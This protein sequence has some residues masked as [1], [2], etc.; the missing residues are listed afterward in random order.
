M[1]EQTI[2]VIVSQNAL[3]ASVPATTGTAAGNHFRGGV[4]PKVSISG[5]TGDSSPV[6]I[7]SAGCAGPGGTAARP[8]GQH[9]DASPQAQ[10]VSVT[11]AGLR[12]NALAKTWHG[13]RSGLAHVQPDQN[14]DDR[15]GTRKLA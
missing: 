13:H 12:S 7:G 2:A 10:P 4:Q 9:A 1:D 8:A 3:I 6:A 5:P 14:R 15:S 11:P